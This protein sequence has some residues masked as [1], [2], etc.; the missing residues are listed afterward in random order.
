MLQ[1]EDRPSLDS[2]TMLLDCPIY[3]TMDQ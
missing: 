3:K 2:T 1:Q